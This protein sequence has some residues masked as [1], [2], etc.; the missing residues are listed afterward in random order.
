M[1]VNI[2]PD[3]LNVQILK[4]FRNLQSSGAED[5]SLRERKT[6]DGWFLLNL[7]PSKTRALTSALLGSKQTQKPGFTRV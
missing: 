1:V 4:I 2:L 5:S 3:I 7:R 6:K